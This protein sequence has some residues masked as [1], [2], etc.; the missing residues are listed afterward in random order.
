MT[1]TLSHVLLSPLRGLVLLGLLAGSAS[2]WAGNPDARRIQKLGQLPE[3][4]RISLRFPV[5]L[6]VARTL[7]GMSKL[8]DK[9]QW[10]IPPGQYDLALAVR[11][12]GE[13]YF[14]LPYWVRAPGRSVAER[15]AAVVQVVSGGCGSERM[16]ALLVH[17]TRFT[18]YPRVLQVRRSTCSGKE[19]L[20]WRTDEVAMDLSEYVYGKYPPNGQPSS[21]RPTLKSASP[22]LDMSNP[23]NASACAALGVLTQTMA[24][25][26]YRDQRLARETA[27]YKKLS[28][29]DNSDVAAPM[30]DF[31][32]ALAGKMPG[33]LVGSWGVFGMCRGVSVE[34]L[35]GEAAAQAAQA[36]KSSA[37]GEEYACLEQ[38]LVVNTTAVPARDSN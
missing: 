23:T 2:G 14:L 38:W 22:A 20:T 31:V 21:E 25:E 35:T 3:A 1:T 34:L 5:E 17:R 37:V 12:E 4:Q 32:D 27:V 11:V 19:E 30:A 28:T 18:L 29:S 24:E 33:R 10:V 9:D 8:V 13:E 26:S 36:C 6:G 7:K 16:S 15:N